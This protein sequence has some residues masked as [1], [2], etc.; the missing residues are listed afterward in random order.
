MT[1]SAAP[2]VNV[3]DEGPRFRAPLLGRSAGEAVQLSG[4]KDRPVHVG[5]LVSL[6]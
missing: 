3:G 4:Q 2:V 1:V 5:F 6:P